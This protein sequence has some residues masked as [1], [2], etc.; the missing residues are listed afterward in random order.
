[1]ARTANPGRRKEPIRFGGYNGFPVESLGESVSAGMS[2]LDASGEGGEAISTKSYTCVSSKMS[3]FNP[4]DNFKGKNIKKA[5][6]VAGNAIYFLDAS[7]HKSV[8]SSVG[9]SVG[10]SVTLL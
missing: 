8:C 1:M 10:P 3:P 4:I 6:K 2:L 5:E 7:S 9:W